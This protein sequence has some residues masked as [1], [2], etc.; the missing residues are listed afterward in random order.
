MNAQSRF[1][2]LGLA[3]V[4]GKVEADA[5]DAVAL[6]GRGGMALAL[7]DVAEVAAAVAADN[8]GAGHAERAV[9]V[10]RHGAGDAVVVGRP[11]AAGL[12]LVVGLVEGRVAAG[13]G[14]DARLRAVFV[15]LA[16]AGTLGTLFAQDAELLCLS[17]KK[18]ASPCQG[19]TM[20]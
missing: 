12:E 19:E 15:V 16:R 14:V 18:L 10:A 11:A 1:A 17:R 7:E 8:L 13:A 9:L 20:R 3:F 4:L 2:L 5:V 6:V